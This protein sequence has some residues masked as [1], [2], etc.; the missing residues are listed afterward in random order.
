MFSNGRASD[1]NSIA[2]STP[3]LKRKK[4]SLLNIS[5]YGMYIKARQIAD[6]IA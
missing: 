4:V 3:R 2:T 5:I 1:K 6:L